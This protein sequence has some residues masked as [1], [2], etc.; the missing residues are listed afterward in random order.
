M[1]AGTIYFF[2]SCILSMV[3]AMFKHWQL[4]TAENERKSKRMFVPQGFTEKFLKNCLVR[5]IHVQK[6]ISPQR[7]ALPSDY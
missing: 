2:Y 6:C 7:W 5:Y 1:S 3:L 4:L